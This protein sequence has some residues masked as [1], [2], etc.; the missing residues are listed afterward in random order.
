MTASA[1]LLHG[2]GRMQSLVDGLGAWMEE[3]EYVSVAQMRGSASASK[4]ADPSLFE[5]ANYM[6]ALRSFSTPADLQR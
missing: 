2:V 1:I 4:V 3:H 5:R 6:A